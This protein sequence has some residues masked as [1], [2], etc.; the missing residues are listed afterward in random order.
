MGTTLITVTLAL[1]LDFFKSKLRDKFP[2]YSEN[3][4]NLDNWA[5]LGA[6]SAKK[7]RAV[8]QG[9]VKT[10][11]EQYLQAHYAE[12]V[13]PEPKYLTDWVKSLTKSGEHTFEL[14]N[15]TAETDDSDYTCEG[16]V[17]KDE[18][19]AENRQLR[20]K[21]EQYEKKEADQLATTFNSL[22][23]K[24][25]NQW[26]LL[27]IQAFLSA[28][29]HRNLHAIMSLLRRTCTELSDITIPSESWLYEQR[30]IMEQVLLEQTTRYISASDTLVIQL[31][32]TAFKNMS[33]FAVVLVN[34]AGVRHLVGMCSSAGKTGKDGFQM[35]LTL[36]G[37]LKE[38]VFGKLSAICT[39]TAS[40]QL[41]TNRMLI[42]AVKEQTGRTI[43]H[44]KCLMHF[45]SN[46]ETYFVDYMPKNVKTLLE[47]FTFCFAIPEGHCT[48]N[49]NV[50]FH[51]WIRAKMV[52]ENK[53]EEEKAR[54]E[55]E[56]KV[57]PSLGS[58]WSHYFRNSQVL[59]VYS[60]YILEF[61]TEV[62]AGQQHQGN[63]KLKYIADQLENDEL[64]NYH[65]GILG[66]IS[67]M[68][69]YVLKPSWQMFARPE[70]MNKTKSNLIKLRE[71]M[72]QLKSDDTPF[73]FI[74]NAD[75][76]STDISSINATCASNFINDYLPGVYTDHLRKMKGYIKDVAARIE[77]KINADW[78]EFLNVQ[79]EE[80]EEEIE[81][82]STNQDVESSFR[83]L[84]D[85][86]NDANLRP[87]VAILKAR[88][89]YNNVL[90][91]LTNE[92]DMKEMIDGAK[93]KKNR[94][95]NRRK[96]SEAAKQHKKRQLATALKSAPA[97]S[98][99]KRKRKKKNEQ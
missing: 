17:E 64:K 36:L 77:R 49:V 46:V 30:F 90:N 44:L 72:R 82:K 25:S 18:L 59:Y 97:P 84:K 41:L 83:F 69:I 19:K 56:L 3:L 38:S 1:L 34:Q 63:K 85:H 95:E 42:N 54:V 67:L 58:R 75:Y 5:K 35:T 53:S 79:H 50:I 87:E 13:L 15:K 51:E 62:L 99:P 31:D 14:E 73:V 26:I 4:F 60:D 88:C 39:D 28:I 21:L 91:W 55:E 74:S 47:D 29:S 76:A 16:C 80:H 96:S 61:C 8:Q 27:A 20:A 57:A 32:G 40:P 43:L 92:V 65:R 37:D 45:I 22:R 23:V 33:Y 11:L 9:K 66:T 68:W 7:K 78:E 52:S 94:M 81:V 2:K 93:T 86:R 70:K 71:D 98:A 48:M 24:C 12:C 6:N 10:V 89:A